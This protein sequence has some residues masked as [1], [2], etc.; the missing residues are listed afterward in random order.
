[1]LEIYDI[2]KQVIKDYLEAGKDFTYANVCWSIRRQGGIMRTN[3]GETVNDYLIRLEEKRVIKYF[4]K[5]D[6]FQVCSVSDSAKETAVAEFDSI[7]YQHM[8]ARGTVQ[9][10]L[11]QTKTFS[12]EALL[13][14]IIRRNGITRVSLMVTVSEH[15]KDLEQA[16][17][18]RYQ[19]KKKV[20]LVM[21]G[22]GTI[23]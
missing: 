5:R 22:S 16:G 10:F 21:K 8:I 12:L 20:Y 9:A 6:F 19:P 18:I 23:T 14:E 2:A 4:P 15:L 1:M 11:A 13:K 3:L 17:I 7:Y